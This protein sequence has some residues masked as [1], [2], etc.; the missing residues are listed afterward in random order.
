MKFASVALAAW[1]MG[2]GAVQARPLDWPEEPYSYVAHGESLRDVLINFAA[3]YHSSVVVSDK[4]DD[5]VNSSFDLQDPQAFLKLVGA[6][7][8]LVW[9]YD[10]AVLYVFKSTEMQT[11]LVQLGQVKEAQLR[12]ALQA[13]DNWE[14][15]FP[16][17]P[18]PGG[19]LVYV[20]APPRYLD[21]VSQ[22]LQALQQQ[23][24]LQVE[25]ATDLNVEIF[26][27]KYAVAEDRQIR[28]RDDTIQAPGVATILS[29]VLSDANVVAVN[30]QQAA[31]SGV[32]A[33]RSAVVQADPSMN[34]IIVRDSPG[35]M[36]MYRRLI[37]ALDRPSARIEVGLSIVDINAEN[38]SEL[39]VDWQVGIGLG[40]NR[41]MQITTTGGT[42][43]KGSAVGS[44]VDGRGLNFLM[45]KITLLQS[46]GL[47]QIGSR[48]TLLTQENTA[49]VIDHSEEYYVKVSGERVAD[50]KKIAY[51]TMLKMTPRV[52]KV[53]DRP[54]ISLSLHIE[55]GN[56]KPNSSGPDGI[57]TISRTVIDTVARVGLGQSLLI[58]GIHRDEMNESVRKVPLLGDIPYLGAL[59]RFKFNS[60]RR[61]V[62][63]FL[64]EPRL[65]DNNLPQDVALG[66]QGNL[67][68][69][70]AV[71]ELSNKSLSLQKLLNSAQCQALAPAREAQRML[72]LAGKDSTLSACGTSSGGSGWRV[73]EG[74]CVEGKAQCV[75]A[76]KKH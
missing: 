31:A 65:I 33:P 12:Q 17:R 54:E 40:K 60:S 74:P 18:G 15:S 2:C 1:W 61:A 67:Q 42:P 62:R 25:G 69:L 70:L 36:P 11:R 10:G 45:A 27:L 41:L 71:D 68:G 32:A 64:I 35:R 59:F 5:Q 72:G 24:T 73:T 43:D 14:P 66:A 50:L 26:P 63:L 57:P 22:T 4:V 55:D 47:A 8:N 76:A 51:G 30:G 75:R 46:Q 23:N 56:Q 16:W 39:G 48:P 38:L 49:A 6:L 37:A 28:Y 29:R 9:Y 13:G 58:G 53:G 3:N 34:A 44:L 19:Q 52:I 20:S 21:M 7:Y